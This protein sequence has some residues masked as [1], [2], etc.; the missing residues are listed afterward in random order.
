MLVYRRVCRNEENHQKNQDADMTPIIS[1]QLDNQFNAGS[2]IHVYNGD[3]V[4]EMM[5]K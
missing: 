3:C 2:E 4:T 5:S 1:G